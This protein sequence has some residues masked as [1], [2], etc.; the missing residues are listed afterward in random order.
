MQ[1]ATLDFLRELKSNNTQEW[2]SAHQQY[3]QAAAA[4][5]LALTS[6]VLQGLS[7]IDPALAHLKPK[8]CIFRIYRDRRFSADK[9]PY[10]VHFGAYFCKGGKRSL[11]AG[12]YLHIQ[13]DE[14]FLAAGCWMPPAPLLKAIRQEIDYNG[15]E[16][17]SIVE[18]PKFL[19]RFGA[20][21]GESLKTAPKGYSIHHPEIDFLKKKSFVAMKR[22]TDEQVVA[23]DFID[24]V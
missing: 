4:D 11:L 17:R 21:V 20:L 7:S 13:P 1:K 2:F 24:Y 19:Q 16:F 22:L 18:A 15:Q 9:T 23:T 10:K 3:Y 12:Y 5:F 6:Q 14:S 8:E